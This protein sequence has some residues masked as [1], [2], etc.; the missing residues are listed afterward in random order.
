[1]EHF[2]DEKTVMRFYLDLMEKDEIV[3]LKD[4]DEFKKDIKKPNYFKKMFYATLKT[5]DEILLKTLN[6]NGVS[7]TKKVGGKDVALKF[8]EL[9]REL[10][11][12]PK[13]SDEIRKKTRAHLTTLNRA[14]VAGYLFSG[15]VLGLGIPNLNI[16]ITN[17]LDAKHKAEAAKQAAMQSAQN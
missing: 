10:N 1:M 13:I 7:T 4:K 9:L 8:K 2:I 6:D 3:F 14:Q 17:K 11:T 15:L 12:N 5:R 16:Y